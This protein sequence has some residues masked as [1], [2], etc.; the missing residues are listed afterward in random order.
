MK[1]SILCI[2]MVVLAGCTTTVEPPLYYYGDYRNTVYAHFSDDAI[3]QSEQVANLNTAIEQAAVNQRPV[4]PG[5]HAHLGLLL[6]EMG[7]VDAG[8]QHLLEEKALF[9]E[10]TTYIDF[11]LASMK[12]RS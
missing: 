4:A 1:H 6:I 12:E 3:P 10:A 11:V 7:E 9:P 5:L 2:L 8:T